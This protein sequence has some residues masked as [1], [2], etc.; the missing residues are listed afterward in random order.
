MCQ[1]ED[2]TN[3]WGFAFGFIDWITALKKD[4]ANSYATEFFFEALK[5][6]DN[7]DATTIYL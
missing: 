4:S 1:H 6:G 2:S 3:L 5:S 7:S